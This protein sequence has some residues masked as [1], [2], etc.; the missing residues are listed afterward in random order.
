VSG[1]V[2]FCLRNEQ[3]QSYL[4]VGGKYAANS[5]NNGQKRATIYTLSQIKANIVA[6]CGFV[7]DKNFGCG[8]K[9]MKL[10]CVHFH[11]ASLA[12]VACFEHIPRKTFFITH[13]R[14]PLLLAPARAAN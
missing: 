3:R 5:Q 7:G 12:F 8:C 1:G 2:Y 4:I 10:V 6:C 9:A 14:P 11:S 13:I